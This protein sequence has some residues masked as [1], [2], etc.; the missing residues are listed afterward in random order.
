MCTY[1]FAYLRSDSELW[2]NDVL[3]L[4]KP[5]F[6]LSGVSGR[7]MSHRG[8]A[9]TGV[10]TEGGWRGGWSIIVGMHYV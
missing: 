8:S 1:I 2:K 5:Y 7:N 9:A 10:N 6:S 4:K 3:S